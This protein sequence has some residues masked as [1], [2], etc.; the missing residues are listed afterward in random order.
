MA[1]NGESKPRGPRRHSNRGGSRPSSNGGGRTR[2]RGPEDGDETVEKTQHVSVPIPPSLIGKT[3]TGKICDI[4][5]RGRG[6]F[7]FI[8]IG[9]GEATR[10]D[11]PRI[12]FNFKDYTEERFPPRR[13]Y[14]VSFTCLE[15]DEKRVYASNVQLTPQG[16]KDAE[17]REEEYLKRTAGE[18]REPRERRERREKRD[19]DERT[20]T[21]MVTCEG[22]SGEKQITAKLSQSI[23]KLKHTATTEFDAPIEYSVYCADGT[24]LSRAIL[25]EMSEG[26]IIHLKPAPATA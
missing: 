16:A 8:F 9:E 19:E 18:K 12:Y 2:Q 5:R 11:T 24:L 14:V 15:D 20:V 25:A 7:G 23:G 4:V 6:Q 3:V 13:N 22:K 26:S 17:V 10:A 21:L 1:E